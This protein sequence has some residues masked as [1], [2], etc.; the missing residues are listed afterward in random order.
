MTP[1]PRTL[2][3]S[4]CSSGIGLATA[5][6][7]R[8]RG[9][10]VMA[11]ARSDAAVTALRG[12]GFTAVPLDLN[13]DAS[14]R[15]AFDETLAW[16]GG[17]LDA[18]VNNAAFGLPGAV[19]DLSREALRAQFETNLFGTHE[20]TRLALAVMRRQ[21]SGRIVQ[22]SSLLG[23]VALG[24]RGAYTASKYALEG[25]SD[26]LRLELHG[27]GI[28][29]VLV[30]PG[31]VRSRFRPNAL[32]A[33]DRWIDTERSPHRRRYEKIR[34]RF[35]A[36]GDVAPFTVDAEVV[37]AVIARAIEARRP[38]ARYRVTVPA[39]LFWGLRRLLPVRWLDAV[40]RRV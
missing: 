1:T 19:E 13:D 26:T 38:A 9:H 28:D 11:S 10:R 22:V 36:Q 25:L 30:E 23:Y 6:L 7:L 14:I 12:Q 3:V 5:R 35:A 17:R 29:V 40:L 4:G 21:G 37:A 16:S 33:F 15:A 2:L 24:F 18:L 39:H 20:L 8:E 34:A 31:P 32:S 27:S